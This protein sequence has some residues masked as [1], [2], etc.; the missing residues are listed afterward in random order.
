MDKRRF[1]EQKVCDSIRNDIEE[2]INKA[3]A[4]GYSDEEID[5]MFNNA[6]HKLFLL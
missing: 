2:C 1:H 4:L 3:R 6:A 5:T